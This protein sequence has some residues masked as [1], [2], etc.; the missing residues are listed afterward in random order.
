LQIFKSE[1]V[2]TVFGVVLVGVF[3]FTLVT[4][5]S[6]REEIPPIPEVIIEPNQQSFFY[7]Q[8]F[9]YHLPLLDIPISQDFSPWARRTGLQK[10]PD[11]FLHHIEF[12]IDQETNWV[13]TKIGITSPRYVPLE[14]VSLTLQRLPTIWI[15][16]NE[17]VTSLNE[18]RT[19]FRFHTPIDI[20]RSDGLDLIQ[21]HLQE[22]DI[23]E[24]QGEL[25][26]FE[27]TIER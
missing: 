13:H 2:K 21:W 6:T 16:R 1:A 15:H 17:Q 24:E 12:R 5:F 3:F 8:G 22:A 25:M 11:T 14:Q 23:A 27:A 18:G 9:P 7:M 19:Y 20:F 10:P 4:Q 26:I